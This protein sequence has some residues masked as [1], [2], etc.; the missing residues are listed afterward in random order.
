MNDLEKVLKFVKTKL[1]ILDCP[2]QIKINSNVEISV[3]VDMGLSGVE[4]THFLKNGIMI[5]LIVKGNID[6]LNKVLNE[7]NSRERRIEYDVAF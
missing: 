4:G 2:Y 7:L 5:R 3:I 6:M 1:N